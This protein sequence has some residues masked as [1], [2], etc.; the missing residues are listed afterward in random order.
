MF[1]PAQE[2][3]LRWRSFAVQLTVDVPT[4]GLVLGLGV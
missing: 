3:F 1:Q 2:L 4:F